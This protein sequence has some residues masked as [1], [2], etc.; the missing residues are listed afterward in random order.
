VDYHVVVERVGTVEM[1]ERSGHV[2]GS[3]R[4]NGRGQGEREGLVRDKTGVRVLLTC[5]GPVHLPSNR[6]SGLCHWRRR[7]R[8]DGDVAPLGVEEAFVAVGVLDERGGLL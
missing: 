6:E 4:C 1:V 2:W 8:H 3:R 5:G 7:R